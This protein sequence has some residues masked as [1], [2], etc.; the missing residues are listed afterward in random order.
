MTGFCRFCQKFAFLQVLPFLLFIF[1]SLLC[2]ICSSPFLSTPLTLSASLDL[3]P[4]LSFAPEAAM[5]ELMVDGLWILSENRFL[6]ENLSETLA[7]LSGQI[8]VMGHTMPV[9]MYQR[10]IGSFGLC[11]LWD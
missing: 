4:M 10:N 1:L 5:I 7:D 8:K 3:N 6:S 9:E 11:L 2:I